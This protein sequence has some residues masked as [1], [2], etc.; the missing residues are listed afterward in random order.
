MTG[1]CAGRGSGTCK[2]QHE[3]CAPAPCLPNSYSPLPLY[4]QPRHSRGA[5]WS[6]NTRGTLQERRNNQTLKKALPHHW[7]Q[8]VR[9]G[10]P[11]GAGGQVEKQRRQATHTCGPGCQELP[12]QS[13]GAPWV[14]VGVA[15]E[16]ER[17]QATS[18][19]SAGLHG[20]AAGWGA[21]PYRALV[22]WAMARSQASP[23]ELGG[24]LSVPLTGIPEKMGSPREGQEHSPG[25]P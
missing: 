5:W 11:W 9:V 15:K 12:I 2:V 6:R 13:P 8:H 3:A 19:P 16:G 20:E 24:R 21:K 22:C 7:G 23:P 18:T 10:K 4:L 14:G 17:L 25:S 1:V